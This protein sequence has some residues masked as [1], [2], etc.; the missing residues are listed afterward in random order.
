MKL[1]NIFY[2]SLPQENL[3]NNPPEMPA[4]PQRKASD[5]TMVTGGGSGVDLTRG[6]SNTQS[7][8]EDYALLLSRSVVFL[9]S[10]S[11]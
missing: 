2:H 6:Q 5:A 4:T 8:E 10:S 1:H 3:R 9:S 11:C 7:P